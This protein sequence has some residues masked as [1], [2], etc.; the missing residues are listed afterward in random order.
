MSDTDKFKLE[1]TGVYVQTRDCTLITSEAE[2]FSEKQIDHSYVYGYVK[3]KWYIVKQWPNAIVSMAHVG[4]D[5]A[6]LFFLCANGKVYKRFQKV[7]TEELIDPSDEGPSDLLLMR[8]M[9]AVGDELVA[10]GMARRAYKRSSTGAWAAID[11][12]CF[13]RRKDRTSATGFNDVV[14]FR[15]GLLACGYKGE[16]W[17]YDGATWTQD[18]SPTNITLTCMAGVPGGSA[19]VIAG[20]GGIVLSGLPGAWQVLPQQQTG[21]DFWGAAAFDDNVY[22]SNA[23]GVFKVAGKQLQRVPIDAN[24]KPST[25]FLSA[26]DSCICSVGAQDIYRSGDAVN[27]TRVINP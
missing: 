11:N 5:P 26:R 20:L 12:S 24:A 22:L 10:V 6:Q 19:V 23:D 18:S 3:D 17:I 1:Y 14:S 9:I 27:W 7:V 8:R 13:V 2:E 15:Q 16:I 21:A 4:G 25:A